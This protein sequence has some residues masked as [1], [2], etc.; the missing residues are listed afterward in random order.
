MSFFAWLLLCGLALL[1]VYTYRASLASITFAL[2]VRRQLRPYL[3]SSS[4]NEEEADD[5]LRVQPVPGGA[6]LLA[7]D[8]PRGEE[9]CGFSGV[10]RVRLQMVSLALHA[11]LVISNIKLDVGLFGNPRERPVLLDAVTISRLE[12]KYPSFTKPLSLSVK[13]VCVR[14]RQNRSPK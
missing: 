4:N 3:C 9:H 1:A 10:Y 14:M 13:R 6:V 8:G 11:G 5:S 2:F 12:M 7:G